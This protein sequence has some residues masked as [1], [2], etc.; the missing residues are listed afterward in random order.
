MS[1]KWYY[2]FSGERKGPV[3]EEEIVSLVQNGTLKGEDYV[4]RKGFENWMKVAMVE[5]LNTQNQSPEIPAPIATKQD[6]NLSQFDK[7]A[8]S[9]FVKTGADRGKEEV[10]YGPFSLE[11]LKKLYDE[12]RINGRT[13]IFSKEMANW[14]PLADVKGFEEVFEE[15]PPEIKEEDRRA[16]RRKPFIAR[17]FIENENTVF[18]GICRDVSVGGMQVLVDHFPISPGKRISINAHPENS[19]YHF[20]AS[21]EIVREL[22]G[23]L[24]FSFRFINLNEEAVQAIN[25]YIAQEQN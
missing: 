15:A 13:F 22:E 18:E 23:G 10:E 21:G 1:N 19:D 5:E 3:E 12:N 16:F 17:M 24:G 25:S 7:S 14:Q 4:W 11:I 2:V 6:V 8:K 20:T 9:F